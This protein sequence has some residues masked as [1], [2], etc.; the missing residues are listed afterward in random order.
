[1]ENAV[2]YRIY[3]NRA[4]PFAP[5]QT[6]HRSALACVYNGTIDAGDRTVDGAVVQELLSAL[7]E[8]FNLNHPSDYGERSLSVGDV[9][10]LGGAWFAVDRFGW[11][12]LDWRLFEGQ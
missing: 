4:E 6:W 10:W 8:L 11:S 3:L 2:E 12:E 7:F 5:F 1:M 9:V